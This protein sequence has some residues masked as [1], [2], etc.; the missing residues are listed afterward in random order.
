VRA[1]SDLQES[2]PVPP[3]DEGGDA[4]LGWLS[5]GVLF[6]VVGAGGL[7]GANLLLHRIAASGGSHFGPVWIGPS[8]GPY[9]WAVVV[10]GL[11]LSALGGVL[12]ALGLR[13]PKGRFVLPGYPY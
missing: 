6:L 2:P 4:R 1:V 8:I 10:L 5:A 9:A 13:A 12:L 3:T 7:V 11:L